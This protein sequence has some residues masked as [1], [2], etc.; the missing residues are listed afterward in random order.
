MPHPI[1]S[2]DRTCGSGGGAHHPTRS[3]ISRR[4]SHDHPPRE[5]WWWEFSSARENLRSL[6][7]GASASRRS[8]TRSMAVG[9]G[10]GSDA[11]AGSVSVRG[12]GRSADRAGCVGVCCSRGFRCAT[13]GYV[14]IATGWMCWCRRF[15]TRAKPCATIK[16]RQANV[17]QFAF[18]L[19]N[20]RIQV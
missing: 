10:S 1:P 7:V 4:S 19:F 5:W 11:R 8:P 13:S 3:C 17:S 15:A 9:F 2:V 12:V 16:K 6:V 18:K 14:R 20:S